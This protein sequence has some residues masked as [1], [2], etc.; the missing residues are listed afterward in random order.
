M[1]SHV[2]LTPM[3]PRTGA[4]EKKIE[5]AVYGYV[6]SIRA[7]GKTRVNTSDI[8]KALGIPL[9]SVDRA[10]ASLSDKGIKIAE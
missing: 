7:L 6:R 1:T 9:E 5:T 2:L 4:A 8:S 3:P 10:L